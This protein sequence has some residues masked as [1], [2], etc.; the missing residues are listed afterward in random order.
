MC[1]IQNAVGGRAP[2]K[3]CSET[4]GVED[5]VEMRED[6]LLIDGFQ[7][8]NVDDSKFSHNTEKDC[9][10]PVGRRRRKQTKNMSLYTELQFKYLSKYENNGQCAIQ[11]Q[12]CGNKLRVSRNN[13]TLHRRNCEIQTDAIVDQAAPEECFEYNK[14]ENG[15]GENSLGNT[16]PGALQQN[17]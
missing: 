1:G 13:M 14:K 2:S 8:T 3:E 16:T 11:C 4:G 7:S 5:N 15:D 6:V 12:I 9:G 17:A 10:T